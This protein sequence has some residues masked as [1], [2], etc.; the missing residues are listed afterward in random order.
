MSS[1]EFWVKFWGVRGS[2]PRPARD[3]LKYGGNTSCLE[4]RCGE[5]VLIFDAGTGLYPLGRALAAER[6]SFHADVFLTHTHYDHVCGIPFFVPAFCADNS[7]DLWA[8]HLLPELTLLDAI[9][10]MMKEPLFSRSG[11]RP[12]IR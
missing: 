5:H 9:A 8:G 11:F 4:I 1:S 10:D 12:P 7:F 6:P 2:F 3:F